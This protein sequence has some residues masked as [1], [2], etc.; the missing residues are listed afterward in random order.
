M[1]SPT[2]PVT[3]GTF[4]IKVV[5]MSQNVFVLGL[6]EAN[7]QVLEAMPGAEEFTFHQLLTQE[8]MQQGQVDVLALLERAEAQLDAFSGSVDAIVSYWDF[9]GTLMVPILC[10]R[11]GL[12]S[13]DLEAVVRC[14][15]KYW[16]RL[17]QSRVIDSMPAFGLLDLEAETPRLPEG[18]TYPAWIK[19][20]QSASSEG[21]YYIEN[22]DD[23]AR[24]LPL[25][26][27]DVVRMGEPFED[28][29]AML[30][31]PPEIAKAGGAAY[32][33]EEAAQGQQMTIEG[34][35]ADDQVH[36]YGLVQSVN[37]PDSSS[38]LRYQYP[39]NVPDAVVDQMRAIS[40]QVINA[41]GLNNST[42]NIEYFWDEGTGRVRLLE[43]N[44][45]HSQSHA[46]MFDMVDGVP[47]HYA[48]VALA[49]GR[50]PELPEDRGPYPM[51]AKWFRRHFSDGVVT[52]VPTPDQIA[53]FEQRVPGT[54]V[55]LAVTEGVRL[56]ETELQDSYS[57]ALAE[58]VTGGQDEADLQRKYEAFLASLPIHID[59]EE[60]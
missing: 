12:P 24:T 53:R 43:V 49:L 42:F 25:A 9:P 57:Y 36:V 41:A 15:H 60:S 28:V 34:F 17:I 35:V 3:I 26:R 31:L 8:E 38:F 50:R 55:D 27:E 1:R 54:T 40:E 5:Q 29:L 10:R 32:M 14:E 16:S 37:Y 21:A 47:N 52:R 20:V 51:A 11:R 45:R 18:V 4:P 7:Q 33:A 23:L 44:A 58:L 19:P 13:A 22:D 2:S 39:A 59:N 56:S 6:D 30:D 46:S 48:M